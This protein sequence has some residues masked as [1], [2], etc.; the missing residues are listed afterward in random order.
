MG[1]SLT[2]KKMQKDVYIEMLDVHFQQN[3][4]YPLHNL[5]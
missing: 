5:I 2:L 1:V 3:I 4:R